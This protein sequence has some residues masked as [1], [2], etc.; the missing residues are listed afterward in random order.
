MTTSAHPVAP[1]AG[2]IVRFATQT[3]GKG[4]WTVESD[5]PHGVM[6]VRPTGGAIVG[7]ATYENLF[8]RPEEYRY[9][10]HWDT[11]VCAECETDFACWGSEVHY[12]CEGCK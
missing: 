11:L 12:L 2:D 7:I 5:G 10:E 8:V 3:D 6:L 4:S 1:K 9:F